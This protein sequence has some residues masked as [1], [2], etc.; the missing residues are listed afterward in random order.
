MLEFLA[1]GRV[2]FT[3]YGTRVKPVLRCSDGDPSCDLDGSRD[4]TCTFGVALC[5]GNSDPRYPHCAPHAVESVEVV[6]PS[7]A[8]KRATVD[9]NNARSLEAT[10]A[11][12][13]LE[14]R[15]QH[16]V[17]AEAVASLGNDTCTAPIRLL[18]PAPRTR[19]QKRVRRVFKLEARG[20][21]GQRDRDRFVVVC[22]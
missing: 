12:A 18:A 14:V 11:G 15:R 19:Q 17:I 8:R 7:A 21:D 10:L 2:E 5:F 6:W 9:R 3:A 13:G 4:G 16:R 22:Q 1:H 20:A